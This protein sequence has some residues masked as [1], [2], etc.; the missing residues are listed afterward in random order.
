MQ[1]VA[2]ACRRSALQADVRWVRL[3]FLTVPAEAMESPA[4]MYE[5]RGE[6]SCP[7]AAPR[8][9]RLGWGPA[10]SVVIL[11]PADRATRGMALALVLAFVP[12]LAIGPHDNG[13]LTG[14][15]DVRLH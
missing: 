14:L 9:P 10:L 6:A 2:G 11:M 3:A 15:R 7:Q 13:P 5:I 4:V 12:L 8:E 1:G